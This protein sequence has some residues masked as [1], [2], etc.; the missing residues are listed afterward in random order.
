MGSKT[1][2]CALKGAHLAQ[3][4]ECCDNEGLKVNEKIYLTDCPNRM[5]MLRPDMNAMSHCLW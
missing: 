1:L 5:L 4:S 2:C 3:S